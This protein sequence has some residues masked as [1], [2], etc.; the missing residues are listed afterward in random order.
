MEK[1]L[2][3]LEKEH[4][5]TVS[6]AAAS[7]EKAERRVAALRRQLEE[8]VSVIEK[9]D[10]RIKRL[11]EV[12]LTTDQVEKLR[13]MKM[14]GIAAAAENKELKKRLAALERGSKNSSDGGGRSWSGSASGNTEGD[15]SSASSEAAAAAAAAAAGAEARVSELLGV[16]EALLKKVRE[17]GTRLAETEKERELVRVA[18]EEAGIPAP[19]GRDLSEAVLELAEKATGMDESFMSTGTDGDGAAAVAAAV[20]AEE[21]HN[22]ELEEVQEA[23]RRAEAEKSTLQDQMR[24][25]VS[26][27]RVLEAQESGIRGRLEDTTARLQAAED[28]ARRFGEVKEKEKDL[29][30]QVKF[31]EVRVPLSKR[32][33]YAC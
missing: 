10:A 14:N 6:A 8:A 4:D 7:I 25:G 19:K 1:S 18:L 13:A 26:K 33:R 29:A 22:A 16:K 21:R 28:E 23:L 11:E 27:F 2:E 32:N 30:R 15:D 3:A 20:A 12:R 31:L 24:A 9:K 5:S 17:Y